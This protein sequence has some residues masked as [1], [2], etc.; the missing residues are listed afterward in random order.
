MSHLAQLL[1]AAIDLYFLR[2]GYKPPERLSSA[3]L[4]CMAIWWQHQEKSRCE[5]A[6]VA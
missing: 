3:C 6:L 2:Y 1:V 4:M 5:A